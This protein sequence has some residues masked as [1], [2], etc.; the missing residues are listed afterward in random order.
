MKITCLGDLLAN[1][2]YAE[3]KPTKVICIEIAKLVE[4]LRMAW[5]YGHSIGQREEMDE[6]H[7]AEAADAA[8]GLAAEPRVHLGAVTPK[9]KAGGRGA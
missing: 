9:K 1:F 4:Q 3:E 2:G 8:E 7:R 5:N 6:H